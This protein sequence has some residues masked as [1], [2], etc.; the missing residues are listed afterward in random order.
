MLHQRSLFSLSRVGI[1]PFVCTV[2]L[3]SAC[4]FLATSGVALAAELGKPVGHVTIEMGQGGFIL[5]ATGG[6][7]TLTFMGRK[8][9]FKVGGLG[10]GE[11]GV[12]KVTAVG[13]VYGLKRLEDFPGGYFEARAGYAAVKGK[14]IQWL[15]NS[16]GVVLQLRSTSKGLSLNLGADGL[17]IEMGTIHKSKKR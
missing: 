11:I 2:F 6:R 17:I 12:A 7:G 14:G 16:N 3:L 13:E 4:A 8:H 1:I 9:A 5:S 15:E 10:V